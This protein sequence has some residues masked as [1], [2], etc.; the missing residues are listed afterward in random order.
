MK[1]Y[2][3]IAVDLYKIYPLPI[4]PAQQANIGRVSG[5]ARR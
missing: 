3:P 5:V 1:L 4:M 2:Y